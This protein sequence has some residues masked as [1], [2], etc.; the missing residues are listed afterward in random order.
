[1]KTQS[2]QDYMRSLQFDCRPFMERTLAIG[3][4]TAARPCKTTGRLIRAN[5]ERG[6]LLAGLSRQYNL[7]GFLEFGTGRGFS[8]GC[9]SEFCPTIRRVVTVDKKTSA[10]AKDLLLA[11]KVDVGLIKFVNKDTSSLTIK[12]TG[13]G[14][15]LFLI[16]AQHDG[17][18]VLRD[19]SFAL[20]VASE[21]FVI[22]FDDFND[23]FC[24]VQKAIL[25]SEKNGIFDDVTLVM[26]DGW[27]IDRR[28]VGDPNPHIE[29]ETGSGMVVALKGF[30]I[31][32]GSM[33]KIL[34]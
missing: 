9:V 28:I 2:L 11:A 20:S 26:T 14:F 25:Q 24:S 16:D 34:G 5:Y 22:V 31:D 10:Q 13:N 19:L 3:D 23:K 33:A 15:D 1:M 6:L 12:D 8:S 18:A 32:D 4:L 21:R 27:L 17:D 30:E 29:R 7:S